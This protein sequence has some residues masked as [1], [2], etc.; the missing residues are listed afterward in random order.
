MHRSPK[1]SAAQE[2]AGAADQRGKLA[3]GDFPRQV[4]Q[5]AI[6]MREYYSLDVEKP[7]SGTYG[8]VF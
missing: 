4:L 6:G 7:P 5:S 3:I 1:S 2:L 8:S